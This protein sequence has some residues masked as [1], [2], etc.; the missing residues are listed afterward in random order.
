MTFLGKTIY[1][2]LQSGQ[3]VLASGHY[4]VHRGW[5]FPEFGE[6]L[7]GHA[8]CKLLNDNGNRA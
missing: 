4:G 6:D 8:G 7:R 5:G 3:N 1:R 2:T